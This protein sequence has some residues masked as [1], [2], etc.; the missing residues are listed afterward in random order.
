MSTV[1]P[2]SAVVVSTSSTAVVDSV[3]LYTI[4]LDVGASSPVVGTSVITL[5]GASE[6]ENA[7]SP[8]IVTK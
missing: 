5:V 6:V 7:S 8:L 1:V 3:S 4:M 2:T